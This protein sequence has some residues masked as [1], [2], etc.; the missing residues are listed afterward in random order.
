MFVWLRLV[1]WGALGH[2]DDD[3]LNPRHAYAGRTSPTLSA[4]DQDSGV[5]G[6]HGVHV[7]CLVH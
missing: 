7:S 1:V 4:W 6:V 3:D 5:C 2:M